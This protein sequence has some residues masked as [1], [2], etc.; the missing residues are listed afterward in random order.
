MS[1][2]TTPGYTSVLF[3]LSSSLLAGC[4]LSGEDALGSRKEKGLGGSLLPS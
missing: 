3:P 2:Y 4:T 1:Q